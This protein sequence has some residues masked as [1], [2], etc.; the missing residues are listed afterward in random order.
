MQRKGI[1]ID[2]TMCVGCYECERACA[3]RWGFPDP[4]ESHELSATQNTAIKTVND[5]YVP[6]MCMHCQEPTCASV[7]PVG[8]F[9]KTAAGPVIYD[10]DKCMGCR[11]CMQACP[12]DV[13]RYQWFDTNPRV[14][15]CDM[16][17][18]RIGRG[19]QPA[20]VESCPAGARFFGTL[21]E[22][23]AEAKR[24]VRESPD[25]YHQNI[26]GLN[27]AGGTSVLYLAGR[28]FD[29]LGLRT[30]LP[31]QPLPGYTW[32]VMSKIPN[33]VFWAGTFLGGVY[34]ITNRRKEVQDFERHLREMERK[35]P[36][37]RNGRR[38]GK[39]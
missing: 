30:N 20:C 21:D 11:Y 1:L 15:K 10:A 34:W 18:D 38:E 8:A 16:C 35:N 22:V 6:R 28:S 25:T 36:S 13:P 17:S 5:V 33:Y 26:Y 37:R 23:T 27:E 32:A 12:F 9:E 29:Q 7:C 19:E 4:G 39:E 2:T 31:H 24:R 3:A 14:T